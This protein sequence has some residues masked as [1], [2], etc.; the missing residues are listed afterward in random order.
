MKKDV[1]ALFDDAITTLW[2][3][4]RELEEE[5]LDTPET[6]HAVIALDQL[7]SKAQDDWVKKQAAQQKGTS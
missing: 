5:H 6:T 3:I 7:L 4:Q 1:E 2:S